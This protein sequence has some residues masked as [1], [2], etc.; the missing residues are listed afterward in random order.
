MLCTLIQIVSLLCSGEIGWK[1]QDFS[2]LTFSYPI[3]IS[4]TQTPRDGCLLSDLDKKIS[5]N[6]SENEDKLY[7][8]RLPEMGQSNQIAVQSPRDTCGLTYIINRKSGKYS[9]GGALPKR[10]NYFTRKMIGRLD[11]ATF[12]GYVSGEFGEEVNGLIRIRPSKMLFQK[13]FTSQPSQSESDSVRI[14]AYK[15]QLF[16]S[17]RQEGI[18]Q[19]Y[20]TDSDVCPTRE[21]NGKRE[22]IPEVKVHVNSSNGVYVLKPMIYLYPNNPT[23]VSVKLGEEIRWTA[24]YPK[25]VNGGWDVEATSSGE[26]TDLHSGKQYYGIFWDAQYWKHP[27]QDSGF[28][29]SSDRFPEIL[30]SLLELKGLNFKE[31]EECVTFWLSKVSEHPWV[32]ISFHD[33]SFSTAHPVSIHPNPKTFIRV[34]LVFTPL[35]SYQEIPPQRI[36]PQLRLGFTAVEWGG[37]ISQ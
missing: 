8:F 16:D 20:F 33:E 32:K 36:Q 37:E 31:R 34:F 2:D 18:Y 4:G 35:N 3:Q 13:R 25:M 9:M 21:L 14:L 17:I 28:M 5:G 29:A 6:F 27:A 1:K 22:P 12:P 23:K 19:N 24:T 15:D 11:S 30:D 26:F 10:P 7:V